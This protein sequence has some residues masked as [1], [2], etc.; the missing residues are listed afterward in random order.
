MLVK[1]EEAIKRFNSTL[2][3]DCMNLEVHKGEIIGLLGP[4]GAGKTTCIKAIIG[5]INIDEGTV[6][7]FDLV[8]NGK[9]RSIKQRIGYVTQEI[10][11]YEEMTA[12]EN[13]MFFGSLY[14]LKKEQLLMKIKEV[15]HLLGL[16]N[17]LNE[18]VKHYSGGMKRRLNIGCS[19]LHDP[20][21]LI[22][23]EPTVGIDP[24]SRNFIL[25]F[26]KSLA[27]KNITILYTSHY[28]EEVEAI[29][30][31]VYIMDQ[32]HTIAHGTLAELIA[33]IKG[34]SH[35]LVDVRIA[36]EEALNSLREIPDI[37]NVVMKDNQYHIIFPGGVSLFDKII[38]ILA[39]LGIVNINSKQPNLEDVFLTLT[40][41]QLR[42]E[43]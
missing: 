20:E 27:T 21:F 16:E 9:E 7:V 22:M 40:G 41:K 34:D 19:I 31:R 15:A 2:A 24:Q 33:R 23:D 4:N 39:P 32:G 10:T 38:P 30:S 18:K 1:M 17:R 26:V 3:L 6:T 12:K 25:E 28:I 13:M 35:I 43:V 36:N 11:V 14:G 42:D 5:L 37:E 8:Q 29:A